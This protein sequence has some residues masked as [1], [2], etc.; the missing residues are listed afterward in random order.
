MNNCTNRQTIIRFRNYPECEESQCKLSKTIYSLPCYATDGSSESR[1]CLP[2]G[3]TT[4]SG[5]SASDLGVYDR[6]GQRHTTA[7]Q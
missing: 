7:R 3:E 5:I 2:G 4:T 1:V 6:S